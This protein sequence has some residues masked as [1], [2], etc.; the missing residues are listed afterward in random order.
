MA[1][2]GVMILKSRQVPKTMDGHPFQRNVK[3]AI[4]GME[5]LRFYFFEASIKSSSNP[6]IATTEAWH[7]GHMQRSRMMGLPIE[8]QEN[9]SFALNPV[10]LQQFWVSSKHV[11]WV[12]SLVFPR[13]MTYRSIMVPR[14]HWN[15]V[16]WLLVITCSSPVVLCHGGRGCCF[17]MWCCVALRGCCLWCSDDARPKSVTLDWLSN[18]VK[19]V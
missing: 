12:E 5:T 11:L 6:W 13:Y 8:R 17:K 19:W 1:M 9:T 10:R 15:L 4:T 14:T 7:E 2:N 16:S 18:K 3:W